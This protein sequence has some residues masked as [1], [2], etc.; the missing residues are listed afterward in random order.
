MTVVGALSSPQSLPVGPSPRLDIHQGP[1]G[2]MVVPDLSEEV[3]VNGMAD[4][5]PL[6]SRGL[7]GKTFAV[8]MG[9]WAVYKKT[10][11]WWT[12]RLFIVGKGAGQCPEPVKI[13]TNTGRT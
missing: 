13:T 10:R 4:V 6:F 3:I 11:V 8:S 12:P 7:P 2:E 9:R 1:N 5:L